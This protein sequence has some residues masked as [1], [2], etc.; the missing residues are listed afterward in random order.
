VGVFW[1]GVSSLPPKTPNGSVP[2][3]LM[4]STKLFFLFSSIIGRLLDQSVFSSSSILFLPL[5]NLSPAR[6]HFKA[7]NL[8]FLLIDLPP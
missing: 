8:F 4:L 3:C 7:E 5:R 1:G 6:R 2:G